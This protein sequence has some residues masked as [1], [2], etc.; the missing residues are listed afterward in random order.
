MFCSSIEVFIIAFSVIWQFFLNPKIY[1]IRELDI[2]Y[3]FSMQYIHE[4]WEC[5][6]DYCE[7][8]YGVP[9]M[10]SIFH[11]SMAPVQK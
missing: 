8:H 6:H 9:S 3:N 2:P 5:I 11:L 1:M 10:S 4:L 7:H